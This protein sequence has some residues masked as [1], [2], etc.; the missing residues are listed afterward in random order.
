[1][2]AQGRVGG[3]VTCEWLS[4]KCRDKIVCIIIFGLPVFAPNESN[5]DLSLRTAYLWYLHTFCAALFCVSVFQC[6]WQI[7]EF[8]VC[9][10]WRIMGLCEFS[11]NLAA[12]AQYYKYHIILHI[13]IIMPKNLIIFHYFN[14]TKIAM[15]S[16]IRQFLLLNVSR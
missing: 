3:V 13:F 7:W 12:L 11:H 10:D 15:L 5:G 16:K 9:K 8:L 1:V 6:K 2:Q 14:I 4:R